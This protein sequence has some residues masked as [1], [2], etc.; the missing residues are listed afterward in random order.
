MHNVSNTKEQ[1]W[2]NRKYPR[3]LC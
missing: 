2:E 3:L 1:K